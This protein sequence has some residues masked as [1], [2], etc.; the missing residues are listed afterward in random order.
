MVMH[1]FLLFMAVWIV[2]FS[3][4]HAG[5][6]IGI[7]CAITNDPSKIFRYVI[8]PASKQVQIYSVDEKTFKFNLNYGRVSPADVTDTAIVLHLQTVTHQSLFD[9]TISRITGSASAKLGGKDVSFDCKPMMSFN[10]VSPVLKEDADGFISA[11][12]DR[13]YSINARDQVGKPYGTNDRPTMVVNRKTGDAFMLVND[14]GQQKTFPAR[15]G[16]SSADAIQVC[17]DSSCSGETWILNN[18]NA[19][20][21]LV[22]PVNGIPTATSDFQY[23]CSGVPRPSAAQKKF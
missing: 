1:R 2:S 23:I 9:M 15:V 18:M 20:M 14:N 21:F 22:S 6:L 12:C 3:T 7:E 8:D 19:S 5:S 4:S 16:S 11:G 17:R 10:W 13:V